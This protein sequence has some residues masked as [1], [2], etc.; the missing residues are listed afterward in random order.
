MQTRGGIS[1]S[2]HNLPW[3]L[4]GPFA[5]VR[6]VAAVGMSCCC[7]SDRLILATDS[8]SL[9][10]PR[11]AAFPSQVSPSSFL[12]SSLLFSHEHLNS[13]DSECQQWAARQAL[14]LLTAASNTAVRTVV[15][16]SRQQSQTIFPNMALAGSDAA[17]SGF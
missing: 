15:P 3:N 8:A 5:G 13:R 16:L 4:I 12:P 10:I 6:E 7:I 1:F 14:A 11:L 9:H 2:S 17:L